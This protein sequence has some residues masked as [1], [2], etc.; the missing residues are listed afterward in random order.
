MGRVLP[1]IFR[2]LDVGQA[3]ASRVAAIL[4]T[5]ITAAPD[6]TSRQALRDLLAALGGP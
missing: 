3:A 4:Q 6:A 1:A 2:D 5:E